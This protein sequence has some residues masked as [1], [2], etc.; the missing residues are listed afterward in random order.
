MTS[1]FPG[2]CRPGQWLGW[3]KEAILGMRPTSAVG[4]MVGRDGGSVKLPVIAI[5]IIAISMNKPL[6]GARS[7]IVSQ[8]KDMPEA[9]SSLLKSPSCCNRH[10]C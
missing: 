5:P 4:H 1:G 6:F 7:F 3:G 10:C 9:N 8:S 2:G